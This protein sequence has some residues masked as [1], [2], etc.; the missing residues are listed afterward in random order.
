MSIISIHSCY[1]MTLL[2]LA[3]KVLQY[4]YLQCVILTGSNHSAA[5]TLQYQHWLL[6]P[7]SQLPSPP[8]PF[9]NFTLSVWSWLAVM[10]RPPSHFSI[11]TGCWCAR[12]FFIRLMWMISSH[13]LNVSCVG[14][15]TWLFV[16]EWPL[17]RG[18]YLEQNAFINIGLHHATV[19][20]YFVQWFINIIQY[21]VKHLLFTWPYFLLNHYPGHIL[22]NLFWNSHFVISIIFILEIIGEESIFGSQCSRKFTRRIKNVLQ[23]VT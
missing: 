11:I 7:P 3:E 4:L 22:K 6:I 2:F 18:K 15:V 21:T 12:T 5:L 16:L 20:I 14:T 8:P 10:T 19:N 1:E 13:F 17:K 9:H 23:N